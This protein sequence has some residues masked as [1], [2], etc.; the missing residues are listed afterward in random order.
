MLAHQER[1]ITG[2]AKALHIG[3]R[4]DPALG[5]PHHAGRNF[6]G[7]A[8]RSFKRHFKSVQ[9]PIVHSDEPRAGCNSRLQLFFVVHFHQRGHAVMFGQF[10]EIAHLA[11]RK[12][13]RDQQNGISAMGR[14]LVNMIRVDSEVFP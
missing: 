6:S 3:R 14:R 10:P 9:I 5:Y 7:Q 13:G 8:K 4:M 2:R 11:F 12:N 1:L